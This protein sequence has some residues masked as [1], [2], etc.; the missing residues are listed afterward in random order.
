MSSLTTQADG[1]GRQWKKLTPPKIV[2]GEKKTVC[3]IK[4]RKIISSRSYQRT[5]ARIDP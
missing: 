1:N 5:T 2:P 4:K 3:Q